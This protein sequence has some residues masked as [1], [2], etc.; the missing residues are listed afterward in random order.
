MKKTILFL[1]VFVCIL[2]SGCCCCLS[3]T[4]DEQSED[5]EELIVGT[6]STNNN[7][8]SYTFNSD[9]TF[10]QSSISHLLDTGTWHYVRDDDFKHIETRNG[11]T[12]N[13]VYP[14]HVYTITGYRNDPYF[15][16]LANGTLFA[17]GSAP[18]SKFYKK[19]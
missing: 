18:N 6:W 8:H 1:L 3:S 16:Y 13:I 17:R 7:T 14:A 9:G 4:Q 15:V 10:D 2:L 19:H 12:G 5:P 11:I